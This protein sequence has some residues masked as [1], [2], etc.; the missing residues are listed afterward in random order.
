MTMLLAGLPAR[1][2]GRGAPA[3]TP[4]DDADGFVRG[5]G[6]GRRHA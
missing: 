1:G 6:A 5:A 2:V 3:L 4:P